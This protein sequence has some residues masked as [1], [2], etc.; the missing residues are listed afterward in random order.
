MSCVPDDTK[1]MSKTHTTSLTNLEVG[2]HD[3]RVELEQTF[4]YE[5]ALPRVSIVYIESCDQLRSEQIVS[6]CLSHD[7]RAFEVC[8]ESLLK[9]TQVCRSASEQ[10]FVCKSA[11]HLPD[12]RLFL[13]QWRRN[14]RILGMDHH[15]LHN[16]LHRN[17]SRRIGQSV[18]GVRWCL[19]LDL[20]ARQ[21]QNGSYLLMGRW[22][23]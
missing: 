12:E 15:V 2:A 22:M 20:Y 5:Q 4:G 3:E 23:A 7:G 21:T 11:R 13:D 19:L 14:G 9:L 18:P 8:Q 17:F 10:L 16:N 6:Q 1:Q